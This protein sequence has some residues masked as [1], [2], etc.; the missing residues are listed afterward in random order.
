MVLKSLLRDLLS[1]GLLTPEGSCWHSV[2]YISM[3]YQ[4]EVVFLSCIFQHRT[5]MDERIHKILQFFWGNNRNF[6]WHPSSE[7]QDLKRC[8]ACRVMLCKQEVRR[9]SCHPREAPH[10][11]DPT[12]A[13]SLTALTCYTERPICLAPAV[14]PHLEMASLQPPLAKL[15]L[16]GPSGTVPAGKG[17]R[18]KE[19]WR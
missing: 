2:L 5:K 13:T 6:I 15:C 8:E 11:P 10:D 1:Q 12:L 9:A 17:S 3:K 16:W 4:R 19:K 18:G 7:W 14:S